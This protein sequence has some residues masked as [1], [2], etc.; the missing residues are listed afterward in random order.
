[1]QYLDAIEYQG[2]FFLP[3]VELLRHCQYPEEN[4]WCL[5]QTRILF[6][7]LSIMKENVQG[8][9]SGKHCLQNAQLP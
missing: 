2:L 5:P 3:S 8:I 4:L 6:V 1:M 9:F 7:L